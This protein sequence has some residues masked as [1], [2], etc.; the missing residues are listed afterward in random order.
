MDCFAD[1]LFLT[2]F[3]KRKKRLRI[4]EMK[5]VTSLSGLLFLAWFI[6]P[7][8]KKTRQKKAENGRNL[9]SH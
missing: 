3:F 8:Q 1:F 5:S 7:K 6:F 4:K 9:K 2:A